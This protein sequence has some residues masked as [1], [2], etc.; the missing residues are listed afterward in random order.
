MQAPSKGGRPVAA[1]PIP[2]LHKPSG[3][4]RVRHRGEEYYLGP[5]G[6]QEAARRYAELL[7]VLAGGGKPVAAVSKFSKSV[8]EITL[9]YLDFAVLYYRKSGKPTAELDCIKSAVRP[10][11]DLFGEIPA[12]EFGPLA[13]KTV[14]QAMIDADWSRGY[15]NKSVG[16]IR[17]VFRWA[18]EN[19]LVSPTVLQGLQAV[20]PLLAGRTKAKDHA[21]RRPVPQEHIDRVREVV[22]PRTRDL[23]DLQLLTGARS[24]ELVGLTMAM[25]DRSGPVW[26]ARLMDHKT[27]HH[28]KERVL[29]FGPQAQAIL[30]KYLTANPSAKLFKVSRRWYGYSVAAACEEL[31]IPRWT[32]HWLRHNAATRL[33]EEYGL[34][35]AQVM[36]GHSS[37]DMTQLYARLNLS[38]AVEVARVSG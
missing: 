5:Y 15:V 10:R 13:L 18:C 24:G 30:L 20:T 4:A 31:G 21:P 14:R 38:K 17:R 9:L 34:E 23:I 37:A 27:V 16:R 32:P 26:V 28:G 25:L 22:V 6:S 35:V 12:S 11:L 36:L 33:R 7:I 8:S 19:E 2:R 3:L 29:V 1:I